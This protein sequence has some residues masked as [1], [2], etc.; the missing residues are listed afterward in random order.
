[1]TLAFPEYIEMA[2]IIFYEKP[3]C[4]N[5]TRQKEWLLAAGHQVDARS[6]LEHPWT[7][8]E[9]RIF[10]GQKAIVECFNPSA[11]LIKAGTLDPASFSEAEALEKMIAD[12]ILIKRP[13]I[14][15]DSH[16]LQGF[17]KEFIA[18]LIS[19]LPQEGAEDVVEELEKADLTV[20]PHSAEDASCDER[21]K[22][23]E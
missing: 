9:L 14:Q 2:E 13:L 6:I 11:P 16:Y 4:I 7:A 5:N 18:S 21:E 10:F 17:D 23:K 8:E 1:M 15:F 20:C 3:G 19:L 12:P 22:K